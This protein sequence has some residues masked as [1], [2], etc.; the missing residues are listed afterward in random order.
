MSEQATSPELKA[1]VDVLVN[2]LVR[3]LIANNERTT[4]D[5]ANELSNLKSPG[6]EPGPE[7]Q[8]G[9]SK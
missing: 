7:E 6:S 8:L 1:L 9:A 3:R 4:G 2:V 5:S